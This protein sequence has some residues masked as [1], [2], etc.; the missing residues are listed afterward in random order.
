MRILNAVLIFAA[1]LAAY[2][3]D[4]AKRTGIRRLAGYQLAQEGKVQG[5]RIA[6]GGLWAEARI[7]LRLMN[8]RDFD[9]KPDTPRDGALQAKLESILGGRNL[10][11]GIALLD[12]S[13][14]AHPRYAA[15]R[16]TDKLLPGSVGK[17]CIATGFM[18]ALRKTYSDPAARE[19]FLRS[20]IR[21]ADAF[22]NVDGK[23]VPF[24][25][26]GWRAVVNRR[27]NI[28]D[29]FSL[30]EWLDHMLSVSSNAAGSF[31]WKQAI[32]LRH[33][34]SSFPVPAE[35]EKAFFDTTSKQDLARES[36]ETLEEP[37]RSSGIDT[38][39]LR[40]GTMFT[41]DGS[42]AIPG[43]ASYGTPRELLRWLVHLEQGKIV[44]EWSS[45]EI[46]RLLYFAR[47][48]YRYASAPALANAAVFFKSGS[49]FQCVPEAGFQCKQ[50]AGNKTNIM[51]SIAIVESGSKIYL[52]ALMSNILK[53]NSASEHQRIADLIEK[54]IQGLPAR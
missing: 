6:P 34:G 27:I 43:T 48:R 46:K 2:P 4:S 49:F 40:L 37:L 44:D 19:K 21:T 17:L 8:N 20:T 51:N 9:I 7:Q 3:L 29:K 31:T 10:S 24:Y 22:V 45:L 52:V 54:T 5:P 33:F 26:E 39:N 47:S 42:R 18:G 30:W 1:L 28:G 15:V 16:E 13:D 53:I 38:E 41:S 25:E 14:P 36:L 11:Y 35:E 32:L 12:I 23:T 50:Y